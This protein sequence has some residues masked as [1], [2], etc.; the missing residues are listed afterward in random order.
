M[1]YRLIINDCHRWSLHDT[2][3]TNYIAQY[4]AVLTVVSFENVTSL[5]RENKTLRSA[6]EMSL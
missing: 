4:T 1:K 3:Q 6:R 2:P 5:I